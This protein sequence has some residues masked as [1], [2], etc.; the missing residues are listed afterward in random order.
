MKQDDDISPFWVGVTVGAGMFVILSILFSIGEINLS[1]QTAN[2]IC[3][4][5]T[6]NNQSVGH[7]EDGKLVCEVQKLEI[8]KD[9]SNIIIKGGDEKYYKVK[10]GVQD[11]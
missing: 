4:N 6:S 2:E 3:F 1:N 7:S 11:E 5:L 9:V 10:I 8:P